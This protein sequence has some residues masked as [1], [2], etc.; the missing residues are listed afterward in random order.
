MTEIQEE[1]NEIITE[2]IT[3]TRDMIDELEP[4]IISLEDMVGDDYVMTDADKDILNSIFRLFHSVKG[5][6]GFLGFVHV[7]ECTHTAENLL[8]QLRNGEKTLSNHHV[9]LLCK[10]C[11]FTK[12][13]LDC[14]EENQN[15][16]GIV[17]AAADLMAAFNGDETEEMSQDTEGDIV[18]LSPEPELLINLDVS[19]ADLVTSVARKKFISE[20]DDLLQEVEDDI[21]KMTEAPQDLAP[22]DRLLK[23]FN[24]LKD[25]CRFLRFML[26]ERVANAVEA[27]L[28][29]VQCGAVKSVGRAVNIIAE[30]VDV[31]REALDDIAQGGIGSVYGLDMY[32][33]LINNLLSEGH[34]IDV[35]V[36]S[37]KLG[38]VFVKQGGLNS[39]DVD[40]VP[41]T[42]NRPVG[43]I[44]QDRGLVKPE[45]IDKALVVPKKIRPQ[46]QQNA[47][48]KR[49]GK[50]QDIRVDL[51]KLD[52]LIDLIGEIVIAENMV[53]NNQDLKDLELDNFNKA[54]SHLA[55]IVRELQ[56]MAMVIRM[57]PISG[58]FRRMI[59]LVHDLSRKSGKK[60]DFKLL[61]EATEVDKT[62]IEKITDPLVHLIRNSMDHGLGSPE[63]RREVGKSETGVIR[64]SARHEEGEVLIVI[65][66][67]GR[68]M[69][70][71]KLIAKAIA[72]GMLE[73]DGSQLSDNEA[74]QLIFKPGF[75]MAE[76]ITD[77]SGRGVGMDVV[78]QNLEEI[79]GRI[80]IAS[81][82][83]QGTTITLHIPLTLAIIDGM[84]IRTGQSH[85]IIPM[86]SIKES[87]RPAKTAI[88][89]TP[90]GLEVVQVRENLLPVL[91]LH[92]LHDIVPDS[93]KLTEGI[94]IVLDSRG[95]SV[96]LFVDELLG[97]QQTVIKGLSH[98]IGKLGE[99]RGVSGCTIL[100]DGEV[101]LI[102]D[103]QALTEEQGKGEGNG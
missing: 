46:V 89:V 26:L 42:Q 49:G 8:D 100:G 48:G 56:E 35:T 64:L 39:E 27:L 33:E 36:S 95:G 59:R 11:D 45:Q 5:G 72:K 68:G 51:R 40:K 98:Y 61:G 54:A 82:L 21:L 43:K 84:L 30:F 79:K 70:R 75:S 81:E 52:N 23:N 14:I 37:S 25:N 18:P 17:D 90:D 53:I 50:R 47:A 86:L 16:D 60:V 31:I 80:D 12:A 58:L 38:D 57:M 97:Q 99:V 15:D 9:D 88:T 22:V 55:K 73:G 74:L 19:E 102:L 10:S 103:V 85:Y 7:V 83:G 91:R 96:C 94:L 92:K 3:E 71:E 77:I 28:N 62:V 13:A 29:G 87:F 2:F 67:D 101:C 66:D 41:D 69:D 44:L 63:E 76:Q 1:Q 20:A 65:S 4:V 34:K 6:A 32:L 93:C 24:S 78:R